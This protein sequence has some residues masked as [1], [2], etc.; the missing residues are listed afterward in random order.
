M[1]GAVSRRGP[2]LRESAIGARWGPGDHPGAHR[3]QTASLSE[4]RAAS[5]TVGRGFESL[6]ACVI[7]SLKTTLRRGGVR[8]PPPPVVPLD[9]WRP[10]P[11]LRAP[12]LAAFRQAGR[13]ARAAR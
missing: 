11:A 2:E 10:S 6:R 5:K 13:A 8:P 9:R 12:R 7:A 1:V 4:T 3:P